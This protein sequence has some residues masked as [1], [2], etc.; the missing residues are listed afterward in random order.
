MFSLMHWLLVLNASANFL[1]Y[2]ALG[3]KFKMVLVL[4]F[5]R[6]EECPESTCTLMCVF[7]MFDLTKTASTWIN[8]KRSSR[9]KGDVSNP[10]NE[11]N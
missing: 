3:S 2:C 4:K 9:V 11:E 10:L 7:R 1:V 5:K 6:S 8:I